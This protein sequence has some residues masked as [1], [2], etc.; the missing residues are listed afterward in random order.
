ML[1]GDLDQEV[2]DRLKK[3][4]DAGGVVTNKGAVA[5]AKAIISVKAE[6]KNCDIGPGWARSLFKRMNMTYR[7][8]TTG[9]LQM[10]TLLVEETRFVFCND[11]ATQATTHNIPPSMIVNFDQTP[12]SYCPAGKYTM[13]DKGTSKIAIAGQTDKRNLTAVLAC[14]LAGG[15]LPP[16]LIYKGATARSTPKTP[17]PVSFHVIANEK[18][19]SNETTMV[20]YCDHILAPYYEAQ[21][22]IHGQTTPGLIIFDMFKA[23]LTASFT[24]KLQDLNV[25]AVKVPANMTDHLQPLDLSVNKSVKNFVSTQFNTWYASQVVA[26]DDD[27][28]DHYK[29]V[30]AITKS[31][32]VL[33]ELSAEWMKK[34]YDHFQL[35]AQRDVI[36]NGFRAAGI[37]QRMESGPVSDDPFDD[38]E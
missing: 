21:R 11:I 15:F 10:P 16:Q 26:V 18:H 17:L 14:T 13:A 4:R 37:K 34:L 9:K 35:P 36:I 32:P 8:S 29:K 27:D 33:R 5:V 20:Q 12:I 25:L 6:Y 1:L 30:A 2:I 3:I 38:I 28:P 19:W 31:G 7:A 23:H 24:Q 22:E